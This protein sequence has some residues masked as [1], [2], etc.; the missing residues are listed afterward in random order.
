[1][2]LKNETILRLVN[3]G[4]LNTT[5]HDV[6]VGHAVYAMKFRKNIGKAIKE[7][8]EQEVE[9]TKDVEDEAKKAELLKALHAEETEIGE[10]KKMTLESYL[11]LSAENRRTPVKVPGPDGETTTIYVDTFR[12]CE[13]IL[14][15]VLYD[16]E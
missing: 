9:L 12:V 4:L 8:A 16:N 5:E 14:D 10:V 3:A 13:D 11:I 1:M 15:G 6:P 7:L 2:K